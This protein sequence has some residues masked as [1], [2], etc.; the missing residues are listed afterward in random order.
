MSKTCTIEICINS[1]FIVY[2]L[3]ASCFLNQQSSQ[4]DLN[5]LSIITNLWSFLSTNLTLGH[6]TYWAC[7]KDAVVSEADVAPDFKELEA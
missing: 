7:N 5:F 2:I 6:T 3:S 4:G 1:N